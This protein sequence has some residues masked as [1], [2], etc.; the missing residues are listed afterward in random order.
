[1]NRNESENS[2]QTGNSG[3]KKQV[4]EDWIPESAVSK[5]KLAK[6]ANDEVEAEFQKMLEEGIIDGVNPNR[7]TT[8]ENEYS[9]GTDDTIQPEDRNDAEDSLQ[10][11]VAESAASMESKKPTV[12]NV[13]P[14]H[15]SSK[16]RKESLDEYRKTFLSVPKLDDRK[17]VFISREVRDRLDEIARKLGGR[18]MSVSGFIEN[19]ARYHLE[20]YH[21]D[22]E[23]WKKL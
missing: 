7:S 12:S 23:V 5:L 15:T 17:P 19:L 16:Q 11:K 10:T 4:P 14:K 21:D 1:M 13:I 3:G 2:K 6:P 9:I 8:K 20:M 18:G 22:V